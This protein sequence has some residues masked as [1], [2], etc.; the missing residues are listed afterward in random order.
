MPLTTCKALW[1]TACASLGALGTPGFG[2][3]TP[4]AEP[5]D[6]PTEPEAPPPIDGLQ[7]RPIVRWIQRNIEHPF[8]D[9]QVLHDLADAAGLSV[10]RVEA[11]LEDY[12]KRLWADH[13]QLV[14]ARG[15]IVADE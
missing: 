1:F 10:P 2:S 5:K 12:R 8:P 15:S 7:L 6:A 9:A 14:A 11:W 3:G 4:V 13:W